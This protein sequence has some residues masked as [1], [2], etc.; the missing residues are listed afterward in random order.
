[1]RIGVCGAARGLGTTQ[2]CL[3]IGEYATDI[4][5]KKT[6]I[7]D[8]SESRQLYQSGFLKKGLVATAEEAALSTEYE[9]IVYDMGS[10]LDEYVELVNYLDVRII[11]SSV[12]PWKAAK[13]GEFLEKIKVSGNQDEEKIVILSGSRRLQ[14]AYEKLYHVK[15]IRMP[16]IE[17]PF[18]IDQKSY[19]F[20]QLLTQ[21]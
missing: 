19:R 8:K 21:L 20:L 18:Q 13:T 5:G 2:L 4:R 9:C 17:D 14:K 15:L 16:F 1:M 10:R 6:I 3:L 12:L 7:I 11:V